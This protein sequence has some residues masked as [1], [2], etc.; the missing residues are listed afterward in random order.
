MLSRHFGICQ[1]QVFP[2]PAAGD[3][4]DRGLQWPPSD[5]PPSDGGSQRLRSGSRPYV[6]APTT[7]DRSLLHVA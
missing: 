1:Q 4:P 2:C 3:V 6:S 5:S 7:V